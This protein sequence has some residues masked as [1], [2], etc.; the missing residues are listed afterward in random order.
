MSWP[1]GIKVSGTCH[2]CRVS[3]DGHLVRLCIYPLCICMAMLTVKANAA[4]RMRPVL[5]DAEHVL[6]GSYAL[7]V[8]CFAISV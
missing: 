3:C 5:S 6:G 1:A 7:F 2:D 4:A 8:T